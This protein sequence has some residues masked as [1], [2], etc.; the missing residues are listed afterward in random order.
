MMT[1]LGLG[2]SIVGILVAGSFL[3]NYNRE[4]YNSNENNCSMIDYEISDS[5]NH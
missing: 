3:V 2:L 4:N 5:L 1:V